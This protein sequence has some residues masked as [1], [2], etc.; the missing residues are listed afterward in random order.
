MNWKEIDDR[1]IRLISDNEERYIQDYRENISEK[2]ANS[3][4]VFKGNVVP[5]SYKPLF[6]TEQDV[7]NFEHIGKTMLKIGDKIV[8][9]YIR[10]KEF[11]KK[12]DF[13]KELEELIILENGYDIN[14]PMARLD[15]FYK[16]G[17]NFKFCELNT[18]GSSAMYE[19]N[20]FAEITL[21]TKGIKDLEDE[22][23]FSYYELI[24]SWVDKSLEI[25]DSW[26]NKRVDKPNI[27]ILDL[28]ESATTLEF[29]R[30]KKAYENRGYN[31]KIVDP[32]N[33]KYRDGNLYDEDFRIDMVYRRLVTSEMIPELENVQNFLNAYRD[34]NICL[35]GSFR[36][37]IIHN[38]L[39]F[40]VLYD[41]DTQ[42]LL[43]K[44]ER[45]FVNSHIPLTKEFLG[46]AEVFDHVVNNK[47]KYIMKP[48]DMNAGEGVYVGRDLSQ[49]EWEKRLKDS[50]NVDYIYQEFIEPNYRDFIVFNDGIEKVEF[51]SVVGIFMYGEEFAGLYTR[52][53]D[54]NV[55][56]SQVSYRA[57]NLIVKEKTD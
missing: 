18:D 33:L 57:A 9:E 34:G 42:E 46:K 6:F 10:N 50:W 35:I 53:G 11:R 48:S 5:Y 21:D 17:E 24:D 1:Y 40:K 41:E 22:Y 31:V 4:A 56:S 44:E 49:E 55:I 12:F 2:V 16:D 45:K 30:F 51:N 8:E 37:Q 3:E 19:D 25:Y 28:I 27:A 52:I 23:N 14:V 43:T 29:E 36:S 26:D 54:E 47:N 39:I 15:I 13:P 38:K 7:D 32:R 20:I